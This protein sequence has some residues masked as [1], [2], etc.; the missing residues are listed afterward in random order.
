MAASLH[1]VGRASH[2]Y[3]SYKH[4]ASN[5]TWE[6]FVV[7]VSQEI[8]RNTH[9]VKTMA[10]LNLRQTGSMEDY[11]NQFDQLLYHIRLY[12]GSI[13]ET[14][15]VSQFLLGLKDDLRQSVEMHLPTLVV[16]AATLTAILEHL[17]DK[18]KPHPKKFTSTRSD[19]KGSFNAS[20]LWKAR[21]LRKYRRANNLCFKCGE[22]YSPSHSCATST[23][24]LNVMEKVA[25]D[26]GEFLPNE[27]L[28]ALDSP[29]IHLMQEEG[30]LSLN[31]MSG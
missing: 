25:V 11:M 15:L 26:G 31:A 18:Q 14:M 1:M 9:R 16:Q 7:V 27:L 19:S 20:E 10:L 23:P 29:N 8:K 12:D 5:H 24:T 22:K 4:S 21:Q 3:Q 30:F 2:W 28:D 6:H 17:N 13:S